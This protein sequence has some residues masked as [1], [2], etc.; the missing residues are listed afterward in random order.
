MIWVT[1]ASKD[2]QY[3]VEIDFANGMTVLDAV[4][5]SKILENEHIDP[6]VCGV[7]AE[8]VDLNHMISDGDRIEIYRPLTI[9]P[10]DIRRNRAQKNPIPKRAL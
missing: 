3:Y 7:F 6:L 5:L 8:K 2:Q 9:N 4:Q 1:Y 10:K